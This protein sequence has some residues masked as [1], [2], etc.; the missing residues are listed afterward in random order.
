[1]HEEGEMLGTTR[2]P[3][4][5]AALV[6]ASLAAA[7]AI[8]FAPAALAAQH[9]VTIANFAFSPSSITVKAGDSVTWTNNDGT[10]HTATADGGSF[11]TGDIGGGSTASVTF[12]TPGTFAYHCAIHSTMHGTIVV[13]AA[14]SPTPRATQPPA[15]TPRPGSTPPPTDAAAPSSR[16][17][18]TP[19]A[20]ALT[21]LLAAA[22][23][24]LEIGRR[25]SR[26]RNARD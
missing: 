4:G 9:A 14:A 3:G 12:K 25:R 5:R 18:A 24:G 20:L 2:H 19:G 22:A 11:D 21:V 16:S 8:A 26:A 6:A 17:D 13:A 10:T 1:M 15:G 7:L 23:V